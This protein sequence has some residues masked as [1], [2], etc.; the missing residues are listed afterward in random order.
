M[1]LTGYE[2]ISRTVCMYNSRYVL[3][4]MSNSGILLVFLWITT[5]GLTQAM[6]NTSHIAKRLL[7]VYQGV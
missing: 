4:I 6:I 3:S 2:L 7:I 1:H 5:R